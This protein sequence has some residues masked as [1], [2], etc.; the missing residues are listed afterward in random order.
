L[1]LTFKSK[2]VNYYLR[3]KNVN[4]MHTHEKALVCCWSL[5]YCTLVLFPVTEEQNTRSKRLKTNLN[6]CTCHR[7]DG[8]VN[9]RN[10]G[11]VADQYV[12]YRAYSLNKTRQYISR[13]STRKFDLEYRTI[14]VCVYVCMYVCV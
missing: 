4:S 9:V 8:T 12:D 11:Q 2:A 1:S 6:E 7:V 5:K 14:N 10:Y 3:S 13:N